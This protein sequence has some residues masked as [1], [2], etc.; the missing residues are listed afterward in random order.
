MSI[1]SD[2]A[3]GGVQGALDG[4]GNFALKIREA[5]KGKEIDPALKAT[6]ESHLADLD[7]N[8]QQ[9]QVAITLEEAKSDKWWKAGWRPFVGWICG[10]GIAMQYLIFPCVALF[11]VEIPQYN[12]SE[13]FNL[14]LAL[15][16]VSTLRTID[17]IKGV[18]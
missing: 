10:F 16:G 5:F 8:L 13:L 15:A 6:L 14:F 1:V 11:G 17:K 7:T 4:I 3:S 9:M 12:F 18:A 2:L